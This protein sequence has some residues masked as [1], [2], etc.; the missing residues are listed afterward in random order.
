LWLYFFNQFQ[1]NF[2]SPNQTENTEKR[3][4]KTNFNTQMANFQVV[5]EILK[6]LTQLVKNATQKHKKCTNFDFLI[7][8]LPDN[9]HY[10][11]QNPFVVPEYACLLQSGFLY[12]QHVYK[13]HRKNRQKDRETV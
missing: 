9:Q 10:Y 3:K 5:Y 13:N 6:N 4:K 1:V 2:D 7:L 8:Q 11:F 12:L